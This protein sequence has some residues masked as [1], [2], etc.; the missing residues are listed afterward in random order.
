MTSFFVFQCFLV[1]P[2][3]NNTEGSICASLR[4]MRPPLLT[5]T[6][7]DIACERARTKWFDCRHLSPPKWFASCL[8]A[9]ED[10]GYH[11]HHFL[12]PR[13]TRGR[14]QAPHLTPNYPRFWR[15]MWHSQRRD[16]KLR[17]GLSTSHVFHQIVKMCPWRTK[18]KSISS[19]MSFRYFSY[20]S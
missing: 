4:P 3:F 18:L 6:S 10:E 20:F 1:C 5:L 12:P 13:R 8:S 15:E 17:T 9:Q 19:G 14:Q 11:N 16:G 7:N 2:C